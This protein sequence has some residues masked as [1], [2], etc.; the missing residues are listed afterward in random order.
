MSKMH[1]Q[2]IPEPVKPFFDKAGIKIKQYRSTAS[3][4]RDL[5][6][7]LKRNHVLHLSTCKDN[8]A[9]STPLEY[10]LI[11]MNFY[12]LSAG[13]AKFD[14]L[15]A[16][17]KVSFSIAESFH[18]E[19]DFWGYKGL[20]AW[21]TARIYAKKKNN[22][23]FDE[24]FKKTKFLNVIKQLG[25]KELHPQMNYRIIELVPDRIKYVNPREGVFRANW[26]RK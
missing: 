24:I 6:R 11:G 16:N 7:F 5:M 25:L 13:G 15:K 17:N 2:P 3:F 20:Q 18:S 4:E 14:Y 8:K 23:K 10:R 19:E 22:K 21:G 26:K 1:L 9:R 12:I